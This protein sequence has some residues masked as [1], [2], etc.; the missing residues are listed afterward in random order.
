M[1]GE[2]IMALPEGA[3]MQQQNP[4]DA[5]ETAAAF[6]QIRQTVP[7]KEF[8]SELLDSMSEMD[9]Q[10]IEQL[11]LELDNIDLPLDVLRELE[12]LVQT[13]FEAPDQ[14]TKIRADVIE[15]GLPE[16]FLPPTFD[17]EYLTMLKVALDQLT[18]DMP[19]MGMDQEPL[20][21]AQGGLASLRPPMAPI[22]QAMQGM[23]RGGDTILAH[24]N[25]QEAA[26][27]Q[28][29]GGTA[30]INPYTGQPEF[31]KKLVKK[32]FKGVTK[33]VTGA[34]KAVGNIVK[35]VAKSPI[36]RIAVTIAAGYFLGPAAAKF[37]GVTSTAGVAAVSGFVGGFSSGILA[38]DGIKASLRNGITS[39]FIA[40]A[41]AG[42]MGGADAFK[43]GSYTGPTT[44]KGQWGRLTGDP[45]YSGDVIRPDVSELPAPAPGDYLSSGDARSL[46]E[47]QGLAPDGI[48]VTT[49]TAVETAISPATVPLTQP[50]SAASPYSITSQGY[51]EIATGTSGAP[52]PAN[53]S[54]TPSG[55]TLPSPVPPAPTTV[56][57]T[58]GAGTGTEQAASPGMW[59]R[60]K[61]FYANPSL[62]AFSDIFID[63]NART[64][65]G[66]YGPLL[67]TG[68]L[69]MGAMGGFKAPPTDDTP[70]DFDP[71]TGLRPGEA[72]YEEQR[73][74]LFGEDVRLPPPNFSLTDAMVSS[75]RLGDKT[76]SSPRYEMM[77]VSEAPVYRAPSLTF[78]PEGIP[79]PYNVSGMYGIPAIYRAKKGSSP[80]GVT[81]FPRKTGPING[82]GT[83]TSDSIPAMLSDGEFVFTAKAVRN[84]GNGSRRKGAARMYKLMKMLE[85]GPVNK[86]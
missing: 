51:P 72:P 8:G 15:Q 36:G 44:V 27:L 14:Y 62:D 21:M 60:A 55:G 20:R 61:D 63:P 68:A 75:P 54:L 86:G 2:G 85:G 58:T 24:I 7:P 78:Q 76:V 82:P 52:A 33:A 73:P 16:E 67:G 13:L 25:P 26:L 80:E 43:A 3:A 83:G 81:R 28:S 66:K 35:K 22:A 79:Q 38:G 5:P 74:D 49:P 18:P 9:P 40:G 64:T 32:V 84:M 4:L 31:I 12:D 1:N 46:L 10:T 50:L 41:G 30:S 56:G 34:V 59:Q 69:A 77:P 70:L 45:L 23:G 29:L 71:R 53:Y 6:E 65:L 39:G 19:E 17:I 57:A 11:R 37:I 48:P 47:S 42:I